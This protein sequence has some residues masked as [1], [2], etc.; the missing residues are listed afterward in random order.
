MSKINAKPF[1]LPAVQDRISGHMPLKTGIPVFS[2][3][4]GMTYGGT[5]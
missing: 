1:I 4:A 2:V 5:E 3:F